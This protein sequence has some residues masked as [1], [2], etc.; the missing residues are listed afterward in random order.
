MTADTPSP[1]EV[2]EKLNPCSTDTTR[3]ISH[4]EAMDAAHRLIN[5]HFG[6]DDRARCSIPAQPDR[7]DDL[8]LCAYIRQQ[9]SRS[10][11]VDEATVGWQPIDERYEVSRTGMVRRADGLVLKQWLN[12]QGY[13]YVRLSRPRRQK[14]V[15]RLVAEAFIPNPERKPFVNHINNDRADNR[16]ENL[17]WC[18]QWENLSHARQQGRMQDDYWTGRRSPRATLSDD[19]VKAIRAEYASSRISCETIGKKYGVGKHAI[20]RLIKG[21]TY[22]DV[23]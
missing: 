14:R 22:A 5:S 15:H 16:V 11:T 10:S 7:D 18:T 3:R 19:Q 12:D 17:E 2:V 9:A 6:N 23:R 1:S 8:V 13:A 20:A 4:R 21:T